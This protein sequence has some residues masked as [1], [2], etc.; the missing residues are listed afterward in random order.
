MKISYLYI[1]LVLS[2]SITLI[3]SASIRNLTLAELKVGSV[4]ATKPNTKGA[5]VGFHYRSSQPT[6]SLLAKS[7]SE[8]SKNNPGTN[9]GRS[10]PGASRPPQPNCP[11]KDIPLVAIHHNQGSDFT[12]SPYPTLWF[13]VPYASDEISKIKFL[14]LDERERKTI[15][16]TSIQL[17]DKPGIIKI[18]IPSQPKYALQE[19]QQYRWR[20]NLDCESDQTKEPDLSVDGWIRRISISPQLENQLEVVNPQS[21][22]AYKEYEIWHDAITNLAELHFADLENEE[23]NDEWINL[24]ELLNLKKEENKNGEKVKTELFPTREKLKQFA[25]KSLVSSELLLTED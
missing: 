10:T 23:L 11:K 18:T 6:F 19:N 8:N 9:T 4:E 13:Y 14:L 1:K 15:Y 22:I 16:R 20:L 2:I 5:F 24:L 21:Y 7:N 12:V 17:I 3:I 25:Q